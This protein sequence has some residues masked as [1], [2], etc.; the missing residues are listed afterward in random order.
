MTKENIPEEFNAFDAEL[1]TRDP[2]YAKMIQTFSDIQLKIAAQ[3]EERS[4]YVFNH[5]EFIDALEHVLDDQRSALSGVKL[6][7]TEFSKRFNRWF[8]FCDA[9]VNMGIACVYS[10]DALEKQDYDTI[11]KGIRVN[12]IFETKFLK[13][14]GIRVEFTHKSAQIREKYKWLAMPCLIITDNS[15]V[16]HQIAIT[17]SPNAS[18]WWLDMLAGFH[19]TYNWDFNPEEGF[20]IPDPVSEDDGEEFQEIEEATSSI[21]SPEEYETYFVEIKRPKGWVGPTERHMG[22]DQVGEFVDQEDFLREQQK[23][24]SKRKKIVNWI[25]WGLIVG[26]ACALYY[27]F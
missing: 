16:E 19:A 2:Y 23:S 8:V 17:T 18:V 27:F 21:V 4:D 24:I 20:D 3:D 14:R 6:S 22:M 13:P 11:F 26:A 5:E 10:K 9:V 12:A 15:G 1:D 25:N 7:M